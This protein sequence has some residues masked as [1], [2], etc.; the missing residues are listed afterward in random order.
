MSAITAK[1][2]SNGAIDRGFLTA[3]EAG[4]QVPFEVKRVYF[5]H[6]VPLRNMERGNHAHRQGEQLFIC[7][8]GSVR[9]TVE[10]PEEGRLQKCEF[11]LYGPNA[12][13]DHTCLYLPPMHWLRLEFRS[14]DSVLLCLCSNHYDESDYI[15]DRSEYES[16]VSSRP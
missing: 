6:S 11:F 15:R 7:L 3:L 10:E 4:L 2:T 5:I 9:A 14:P 1:L 8:A 16:L 13:D 12:H